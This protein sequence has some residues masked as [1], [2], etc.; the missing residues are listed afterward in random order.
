MRFLRE[1]YRR[2]KARGGAPGMDGV[3]FGEIEGSGLE[4][5]LEGIRAELKA[6]KYVPSP[7]LRVY[8]PKANGKQ[9]PLGIPTIRDRVIQMACK[10][11]IE[12]ISRGSP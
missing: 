2:V 5:F 11:V 3:T 9:R 1:A 4:G 12:P 8:L 6:Q 10:L 7:V